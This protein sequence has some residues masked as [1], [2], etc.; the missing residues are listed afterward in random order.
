M[1]EICTMHAFLARGERVHDTCNSHVF[2]GS[3]HPDNST[4]ASLARHRTRICH[5]IFTPETDM[6]DIGKG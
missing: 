5:Q 4:F 6:I 1:G 2:Q 3:S